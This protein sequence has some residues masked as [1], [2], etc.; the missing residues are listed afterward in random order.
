MHRLHYSL[1]HTTIQ[2][3]Y[4]QRSRAGKLR[5]KKRNI[6]GYTRS[7]Q[8]P[9]SLLPPLRTRMFHS[10]CSIVMN[11][12]M[13][14][15]GISWLTTLMSRLKKYRNNHG[16]PKRAT[17]DPHKT[18]ESLNTSLCATIAYHAQLPCPAELRCAC[19]RNRRMTRSRLAVVLGRVKSRYEQRSQNCSFTSPISN[20]NGLEVRGFAMERPLSHV[21]LQHHIGRH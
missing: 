11:R 6:T 17:E 2:F 19:T 14:T 12:P 8:P 10:T 3:L 15:A 9:P 20:E 5:A 18:D 21:A 13:Q 1:P 16:T 4:I 7:C